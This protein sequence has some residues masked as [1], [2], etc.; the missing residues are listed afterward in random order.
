MVE[1]RQDYG[2]IKTKNNFI[3]EENVYY[4]EVNNI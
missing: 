1:L 3:K 4:P 2:R